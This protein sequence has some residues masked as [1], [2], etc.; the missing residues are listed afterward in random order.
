M[1]VSDL[2]YNV[3]CGVGG[4]YLVFH[5]GSLVRAVCKSLIYRPAEREN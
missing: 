1:S 2:F 4:V 5:V 3:L